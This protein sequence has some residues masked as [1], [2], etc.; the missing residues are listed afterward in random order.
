MKK[1][2]LFLLLLCHCATSGPRLEQAALKTMVIYDTYS[3]KNAKSEQIYRFSVRNP[4]DLDLIQSLPNLQELHID[5]SGSKTIPDSVFKLKNLTNLFVY[6][7]LESIP[8][9][10]SKLSNLE[11]LY[12][13]HAKLSG[14]PAEISNLKNLKELTIK[15]YQLDKIPA[16]ILNLTKLEKLE[17]VGGKITEVPKEI[18]NLK[19]L[20]SINISF[21]KIQKIS[22]ELGK[23]SSLQEVIC[24]NNSL[25][26]VPKDLFSKMNS[27]TK[28]SFESN[29][30]PQAYPTNATVQAYS[31]LPPHQ[32][33]LT[34]KKDSPIFL[35]QIEP[36]TIGSISGNWA[37][38][39][40]K[41]NLY[42]I[43]AETLSF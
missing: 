43:L 19:N 7:F 27:L 8:A 37:L 1:I 5:I 30:I 36:K 12:L 10:I 29:Q 14:L 3:L 6:S 26:T 40:V 34:V 38:V 4:E 18:G 35:L 17:L 2:T 13:R 39:N 22:A 9:D 28:V 11:V 16:E 21:N 23:L 24:T 20:K 42:Y 31:Y 33:T 32:N 15:E 25:R 41:D